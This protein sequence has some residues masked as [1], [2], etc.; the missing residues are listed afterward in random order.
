MLLKMMITL[1]TKLGCMSQ[2]PGDMRL[3]N[4]VIIEVPSERRDKD[5][6]QTGSVLL[7]FPGFQVSPGWFCREPVE[8]DWNVSAAQSFQT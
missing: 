6:V 7:G 5:L 4:E 8:L 3:R 2:V 1:S